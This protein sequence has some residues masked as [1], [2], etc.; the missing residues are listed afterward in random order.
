MSRITIRLEDVSIEFPRTRVTLGSIERSVLR[1]VGIGVRREPT[2]TALDRVSLEVKEGEVLGLVGKNGAG[3]S[4][5]LRV[6]AGIYRPDRGRAMR[7]G[8]VSLLAGLGVGFNVNLSG[9]ENAYI[10]GSILGHPR[11]AIDQ[12]ID[13]IIEFAGLQDFIDQPL[14]TYSNGMRAR[15]GFSIATAIRPEILA[16]DEVLAVGDAEFKEQSTGRIREMMEKAGTVL[17]ASHSLGLLKQVCTRA[18]LV[19]KGTITMTGSP[20]EVIARY[21]GDSPAA[22]RRRAR[23]SR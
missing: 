21:M 1:M 19:E 7:A 5:L 12:L 20:E 2:F 13:S 3:K 17:L 23:A 18:I 9:R 10:Y 15:L 4:T 16:I 14:R 8:R 6:I 22:L 11:S